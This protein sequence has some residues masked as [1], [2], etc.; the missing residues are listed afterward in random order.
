MSFDGLG[1]AQPTQQFSLC[2]L[3]LSDDGSSSVISESEK[4]QGAKQ[5]QG[6]STPSIQTPPFASSGSQ[7][8]HSSPLLAYP[9]SIRQQL[10]II[11]QMEQPIPVT[12]D[13]SSISSQ[14]PQSS[15]ASPGL[16]RKRISKV[17]K[18]NERGETPLH[19]AAR[20]GEHR[21]C[22]KLVEEGAFVNARDYAGW[23]PLHEACYHGHFKVAKL[24]LD[25]DADVNALSDCDDTPLHDAVTSGNEKLVWLLLHSGAIRDRV[26]NDGKKPI[27]ICHSEYS[28]IRNL[29]STAVIPELYPIDE[30][31]SLSPS[32]PSHT[33]G[34]SQM[35]TV[36]VMHL[37]PEKHCLT[38]SNSDDSVTSAEIFPRERNKGISE[39]LGMQLQGSC[40]QPMNG[41]GDTDRNTKVFDFNNIISRDEE[42]KAVIRHDFDE[43]D[44]PFPMHRSLWPEERSETLKSVALHTGSSPY[45][46]DHDLTSSHL[47]FENT[48]FGISESKEAEIHHLGRHRGIHTECFSPQF[49]IQKS[50]CNEKRKQRG[51][52]RGRGISTAAGSATITIQT[53][54]SDDVYEFRSSP[55]S[56]VGVNKTGS[57]EDMERELSESPSL[58]RQ[59]FS[60]TGATTTASFTSTTISSQT[61]T[62]QEDISVMEKE[63]LDVISNLSDLTDEKAD[64]AVGRKVPPL[65]ISLPR[66]PTEDGIA[67]ATDDMMSVTT[68]TVRRNTRSTKSLT[69]KHQSPEPSIS[70]ICDE[71]IQRVT[72]S[73]LRQSGRQLRDHPAVSYETSA[74]RKSSSWRRSSTTTASPMPPSSAATSDEQTTSSND[75]GDR[76]DGDENSHLEA[77]A[78]KDDENNLLALSLMKKN[79]YE[80]FRNFR[81]VIE[82]RWAKD[83][84]EQTVIPESP[85]N[86][87]NYLIVQGNYTSASN[88]GSLSIQEKVDAVFMEKLTTKLHNLYTEQDERR[89]NMQIYHQVERERLRMQAE[90][91]VMR[92]LTRKANE[93]HESFSTMR[94]IRETNLFN[95]GF[96]EVKP[97]KLPVMEIS[98]VKLKYEKLVEIMRRRQQMEADALYAEQVFIWNVAVQ[99]SE[100]A[101]LLSLKNAVPR[102]LVSSL[103]LNL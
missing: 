90:S 17:H 79:S 28:G 33:E 42:V 19:V 86:F 85:P 89:R 100:D 5:R 16:S 40:S 103:I 43:I 1:A 12:T 80:G 30:S 32:S 68:N 11:K 41:G 73:K 27:D 58:K 102:V 15:S 57:A 38:S 75:A 63:V 77:T 26:D 31:P 6:S 3:E 44:L 71:S 84:T 91:E 93:R 82:E 101:T 52:R 47:S 7:R 13:S 29:L 53:S 21:L 20:K 37:T 66:T 18:K 4:F 92:M 56:D 99:R 81:S 72:R 95:T 98:E 87:N 59:R 67:S 51:R 83:A 94:M 34:P 60:Q 8:A 46:F 96:L 70:N 45:E 35:L 64:A 55:E 22:K 74:K 97:K 49:T 24:L 88:L 36:N 25:Y 23:T 39:E 65:R 54:Q 78:Q 14:L 69:R 76:A 9:V 62:T 2:D 61:S 48:C 10:A 50:V